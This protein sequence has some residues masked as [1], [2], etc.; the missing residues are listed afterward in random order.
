MDTDEHRFENGNFT[1]AFG[2]LRPYELC[3]FASLGL[4]V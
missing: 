2:R 1:A 4:C 3:G